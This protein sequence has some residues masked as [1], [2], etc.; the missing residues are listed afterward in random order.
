MSFS[1][2]SGGSRFLRSEFMLPDT[3]DTLANDIKWLFAQ[4]LKDYSY[5]TCTC[6]EISALI[7]A[8]FY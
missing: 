7:I 3:L 5:D 4:G 6:I 2:S 1:E 8:V